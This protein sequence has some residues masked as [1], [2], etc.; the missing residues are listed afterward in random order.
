[1]NVET[2]QPVHS[3]TLPEAMTVAN[4]N[5]RTVD[6][7]DATA[8]AQMVGNKASS[9]VGSG[10]PDF[11]NATME[12]VNDYVLNSIVMRGV[13]QS[14]EHRQQIREDTEEQN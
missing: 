2:I 14:A 8:F 11:S 1:M 6:H 9:T 4:P 3:A 7:A 12:T 10:E 13:Y 5:Q